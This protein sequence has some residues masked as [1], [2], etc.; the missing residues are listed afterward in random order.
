[1][2]DFSKYTDEF[3]KKMT[4]TWLT[5]RGI[6]FSEG[7]ALFSAIL[8]SGAD[9]IIESG[10]AYG[11]SAEMLAILCKTPLITV[12]GHIWYEGSEEYSKKRLK[13]YKHVKPVTGNSWFV[14]PELI[15][16]IKNKKVALF[17]DGPKEE[18]ALNMIKMFL[19]DHGHQI[20]LVA[21]HDVRHGTPLANM[22]KKNYPQVLFTDEEEGPFTPYRHEIDQHMLN[23]NKEKYEP[24]S[25]SL[26]RN[27]G[28]GYLQKQMEETPRGF[29]LAM[30]WGPGFDK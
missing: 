11:G 24:S 8:E 23:L 3:K 29:G 2:L 30:W 5:P 27:E 22:Y 17:I 12:D 6:F 7:F 9:F 14:I 13:K 21:S 19:N 15:K 28:A 1:M 25:S 20:V 16:K 10:T 18:D 26:D 4:D